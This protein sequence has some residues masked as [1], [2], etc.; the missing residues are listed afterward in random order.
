[1]LAITIN[2]E[3]LQ[4]MPQRA[5]FRP[6]NKTLYI[7]DTHWGKDETF[8][9][10]HIPLP[11][12]DLDENLSRLSFALNKTLAERLVILGD[13]LHT[14]HSLSRNIIQSIQI[15]RYTHVN[16]EILLIEGN[17]DSSVGELPPEWRIKR[18]SSFD[19]DGILLTHQPDIN[20]DCFNFCGH[21]HPTWKI[22][23]LGKQE[24]NLPCFLQIDQQVI[25]PA[26]S[27]FS[28]SSIYRIQDN[29]H[30]Y[31]LTDTQVFKIT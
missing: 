7:A 25:F 5:L 18:C 22:K 10:H 24:V 13:L 8:R 11:I 16:L 15:W 9:A 1:M 4:L 17:H 26:F 19:D 2:S 31:A 29:Q 3:S 6:K 21:L 20:T 27:L 23:G 30:V 14:S 12:G 28:G